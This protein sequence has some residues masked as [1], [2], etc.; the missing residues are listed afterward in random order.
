MLSDSSRWQRESHDSHRWRGLFTVQFLTLGM[1]THLQEQREKS[2]MMLWVTGSGSKN[3]VCVSAAEVTV[4]F[5]LSLLTVHN[6]TYSLKHHHTKTN[7]AKGHRLDLTPMQKQWFRRIHVPWYLHG[8]PKPFQE[9]H[10]C[11]FEKHCLWYN[12]PCFW[13]RTMVKPR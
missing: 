1:M 10:Y 11:K 3:L 5:D 7:M 13:T 9:Y 12:L 4:G 2:D 6:I 8:S